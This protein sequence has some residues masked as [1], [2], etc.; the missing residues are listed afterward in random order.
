M[1]DSNESP[2]HPTLHPLQLEPVSFKTLT[3]SRVHDQQALLLLPLAQAAAAA[4]EPAPSSPVLMLPPVGSPLQ[5]SSPRG[6]GG[7]YGTSPMSPLSRSFDRAPSWADDVVF[8]VGCGGRRA[9]SPLPLLCRMGAAG[10]GCPLVVSSLRV[11][12]LA[13]GQPS[14][15]LLPRPLTAAP[16]P[17]SCGAEPRAG[18]RPGGAGQPGQHVLHELEPA[19]PGP[20]PATHANLPLGSLQA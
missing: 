15:A 12:T 1:A 5:L 11:G 10:A 3:G 18:A 19:V 4:A 14:V 9:V 16:L 13:T 7:F 8:E 17:A 2:C 20:Q 6:S